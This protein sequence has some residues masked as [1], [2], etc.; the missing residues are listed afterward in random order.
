LYNNGVE[1]P[2]EYFNGNHHWTRKFISWLQD[3]VRLLSETRMSLD[4]LIEDILHYRHRLLTVNRKLRTLAQSDKYANKYEL[5]MSI[6]GIGTT[7][8]MSLLTEIDD[9]DRFSNQR[10]FASFLGLIPMMSSSGNKEYV[11]EKTFRG[12]KQLGPRIVEAS[13]ISIRHDM[14]LS[15]KYGS[16]CARGM[17]PQEAIIR[18]ARKLSNI[19]FSVLKSNHKY[20]C[21]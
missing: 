2:D 16:L 9:I 20:E 13:W 21:H 6:P 15:A 17:K 7:I 5:L 8:A 10:Q 14:E 4:M 3:D 12:N 19:I 18:I 11:G 1:Y